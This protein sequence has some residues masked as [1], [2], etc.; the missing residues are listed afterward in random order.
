MENERIRRA[1]EA[2]L[3]GARVAVENLIWL[4]EIVLKDV[5][6]TAVAPFPVSLEIIVG[7]IIP[8]RGQ[9]LSQ[10]LFGHVTVK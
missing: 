5:L 10:A 8:D 1:V 2:I 3:A 4:V 6:A 9:P 7:S